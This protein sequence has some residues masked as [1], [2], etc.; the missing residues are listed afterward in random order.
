MPAHAELPGL[1]HALL[2]VR[3]DQ[4]GHTAGIV[5]WA[6][7]LSSVLREVL[8]DQRVYQPQG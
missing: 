2:E 3:Q 7:R 1:P 6:D 8:A 5:D 4:I